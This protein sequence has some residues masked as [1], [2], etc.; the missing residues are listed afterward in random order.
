MPMATRTA[1]P[2]TS[3]TGMSDGAQP[4]AMD[5]SPTARQVRVQVS[6]A[7][8]EEEPARANDSWPTRT[9][10]MARAGPQPVA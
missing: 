2:W 5:A 6:T 8:W 4:R 7:R 1:S 10:P 9:S 3:G